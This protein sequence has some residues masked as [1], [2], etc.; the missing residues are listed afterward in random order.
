LVI[1]RV[2]GRSLGSQLA[3]RIIQPLRLTDTAFTPG[4]IPGVHVHGYSLPS[5]QGVVDPAAEPRDLETRSARWAGAS[6]DLVSSAADL[7]RF[8]AALLTGELLPPVQLHAMEAVRSRYGLGLAVY[9]TRCGR[10]W[11]HTGN[12]NG[13]LTVAWSTLDGRRQAVVVANAFPLTPA[14]NAA[15]RRAAVAA[16]CDR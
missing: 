5:H 11:G 4:P 9:P 15:L 3:A 10:A 1:E 12:L 8:L 13:V 2:T 14:G 7:A 16:F 6:G